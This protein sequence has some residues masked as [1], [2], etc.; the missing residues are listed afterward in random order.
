M[1]GKS[2]SLTKT[3]MNVRVKLPSTPKLQFLGNAG[4]VQVQQIRQLR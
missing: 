3:T 2:K 1:L 4:N